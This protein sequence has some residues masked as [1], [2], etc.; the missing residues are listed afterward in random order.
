MSK[1][2]VNLVLA[3]TFLACIG[4]VTLLLASQIRDDCRP[5]AIGQLQT[6]E[7]YGSRN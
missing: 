7:V 2:A 5:S 1:V 4:V 3:H 6:G